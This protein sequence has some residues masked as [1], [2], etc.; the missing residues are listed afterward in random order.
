M[1]WWKGPFVGHLAPGLGLLT[2][3]A[4]WLLHALALG[5][6]RKRPV[7]G[8][9]TGRGGGGYVAR[10]CF[11]RAE[12]RVRAAA[13]LLALAT[14]TASACVNAGGALRWL[15]FAPM[16]T[17]AGMSVASGPA[18][19]MST[20]TTQPGSGGGHQHGH[21]NLQ[22][23][24]H[25]TM[26]VAL[27]LSCGAEA[28]ERRVSAAPRGLGLGSLA[29]ALAM[30]TWLLAQHTALQ[31]PAEALRHRLLSA[32]LAAAALAAAVDVVAPRRALLFARAF[33]VALAGAWMAHMALSR[34]L[35]WEE[36]YEPYP[37][38]IITVVTLHFAWCV[39]AC[40]KH[41]SESNMPP[42]V[43][44]CHDAGHRGRCGVAVGPFPRPLARGGGCSV[45]VG[46]ARGARR[47]QRVA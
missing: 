26:H 21:G 33:G 22:N 39:F 42:S 25:G 40:I 9:A 11:S 4:W 27:L 44:V 19:M 32:P 24:Y 1:P 30:V 36:A 28:L 5:G 47:R 43:Q 13:S 18:E 16:Q 37:A 20:M 8:V 23:F 15:Y 12:L 45:T 46:C 17:E 14:E 2:W 31:G 35:R 3:G 6:E 34:E 29:A 7:S 41:A 10:G 38:A